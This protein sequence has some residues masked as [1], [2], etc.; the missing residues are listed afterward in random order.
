MHKK[1]IRVIALLLAII[2]LLSLAV[3]A[4]AMESNTSKEEVVYV[5]LKDDGAVDGTYVVNIFEKP[6]EGSIIDYGNY[7]ALRNLSTTEEIR[8]AGDRI[9]LHTQAEKLYYQGT[10]DNAKLPWS[11]SIQYYLD[12]Q[13]W[14]PKAL[15]GKNGSLKIKMSLRQNLAAD[16]S[17]FEH[18]SLQASFTL[19]TEKCKDIQA[20]GA[21][22]ANVGKNK[23]LTYTLLPGDEKDILIQAQVTDFEMESIQINGVSLNLDV[24]IPNTADITDRIQSLQKGIGQLDS[25]AQDLGQGVLA[26]REGTQKLKAGADTLKKGLA[27][28]QKQTPQLTQGSAQIKTSIDQINSALEQITVSAASMEE[29]TAGSTGVKAGIADLT[30]GILKLQK[31]F[32]SYSAAL[33]QKGINK[34][35]LLNSNRQ[36]I[37]SLNSQIQGLQNTLTALKAQGGNTAELETQL[38]GLLELKQLLEANNGLI[39]ADRDFIAQLQTGVADL[40][41]GAHTL[42]TQYEQLDA[43][44]QELPILLNTMAGSLPKLKSAINSLAEN[45]TRFDQGVLQYSD[46]LLQTA[47]GYN[48]LYTGILDA[49]DGMSKLQTATA[50]LTTGTGQLKD[51]TASMDVELTDKINELKGKIPSNNFKPRSFVSDKNTNL[52]A[53]QFVIKTNPIE[54]EDTA[55]A[56]VDVKK[57][58]TLWQK[59]LNLFGLYSL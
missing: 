44:I 51:K 43:A 17:F 36:T 35:I 12:N 54:K 42:Q 57:N 13:A 20:E 29:L 28:L 15:A 26:L 37:A 19:N 55:V 56:Q 39:G 21:T 48:S 50:D 38:A 10:L 33:A 2:L 11:I 3:P 31:G 7:S 16:Q 59:L 46:G 58:L 6:L 30:E 22:I 52:K 41:G 32:D 4:F 23:Q 49:A 8:Q 24:N 1:L 34:E 27:A 18:Y 9:S 14:E 47:E 53:V 40:Y 25:G 45:Y 5:N